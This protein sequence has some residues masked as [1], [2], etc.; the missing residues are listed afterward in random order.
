[1]LSRRGIA[2]AFA[3]FALLGFLSY[4]LA[5]LGDGGV[6]SHRP[7]AQQLKE[8][9]VP[10]ILAPTP[11]GPPAHSRSGWRHVLKRILQ[12]VA[13]SVV[14]LL[15]IGTTYEFLASRREADL[16]PQQGKSVQ[17]SAEF[18]NISLNLNCSGPGTDGSAPTVILDS[19][20]GVPGIGW[21]LVQTEVAKFARVCS[22]DRAGYAWS[23]ES[24]QPRTSLQIATELH[25]LLR[26]AGEKG[27]FVLVGHSFGGYNVRVY[28]GQYP[29][30]VVGM[31]LVDA[32]HEDQLSRMPPAMKALMQPPTEGQLRVAG[33]LR[34]LGILRALTPAD[35]D[36][37]PK[38][39]AKQL[40]YLQLLPKNATAY[41]AEL[42]SFA[43]SSQQVRAAGK[44]DDRP[45]IVL[46]AGKPDSTTALAMGVPQKDI[47]EQRRVWVDE[48]QVNHAELSTRGKRIIVMDSGHMIPF[49]RP[50]AVVAAI[51]E[52]WEAA[53]ASNP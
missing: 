32:S 19:G 51:R 26:A 12:V 49:E 31:V 50:D 42:R 15:I 1:M 48:F 38:E 14:L 40:A 36:G 8:F 30:E 11:A 9:A 7:S 29:Q 22:Y 28:T 53:R 35:S 18:Q 21:K 39:L 13:G 4:A 46:T 47:D 37:L 24:R 44:L 3:G 6:C 10:T 41:S 45:L 23:D 5:R 25:A 2:A 20:L 33:V 52:V 16:F 17:L 27:P 43:L 34:T